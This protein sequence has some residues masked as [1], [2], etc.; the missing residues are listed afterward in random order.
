VFGQDEE[1]GLVSL[2]T[3]SPDLKDAEAVRQAAELCPSGAL[4]IAEDGQHENPGESAGRN[5]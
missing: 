1:L 4:S 3:E 5:A 2:L